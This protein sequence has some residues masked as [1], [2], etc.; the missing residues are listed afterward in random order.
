MPDPGTARP[1]VASRATGLSVPAVRCCSSVRAQ[2]LVRVPAWATT[3]ASLVVGD[4]RRPVQPGEVE[5]TRPF[6]E[7][8]VVH[9]ELPVRARWTWPHPRID[10]VRGQVAVERGP[11]VMCLESTDLGHTVDHAR[12]QLD[13]APLERDGQVLVQ[14]RTAVEDGDGWPYREKPAD[15]T[16]DPTSRL[17]P[18][19]PY[20]RWGNRGLCTMRVWI[21]TESP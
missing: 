20:H 18:L 21:P 11:L 16:A 12:I 17:V 9:L 10:A 6:A 4:E 8:D 3:G 15:E 19:T 14:V 1:I 5:I 7:G 2:A 13:D